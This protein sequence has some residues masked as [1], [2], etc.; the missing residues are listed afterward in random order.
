MKKAI[1][2]P[3]T[4][5]YSVLQWFKTTLT[6][7]RALW[8]TQFKIFKFLAFNEYKKLNDK[9]V[10]KLAFNVKIVFSLYIALFLS[11]FTLIVFFVY[12]IILNR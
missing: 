2:N 9:T 1:F 6:N 10:S 11:A 12:S 8:R 4:K 3:K 7:T 5:K